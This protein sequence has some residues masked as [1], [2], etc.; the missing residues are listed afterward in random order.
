[1]AEIFRFILCRD[2]ASAWADAQTENLT[3][4]PGPHCRPRMPAG[5]LKTPMQRDR[6]SAAVIDNRSA[7]SGI[8]YPPKYAIEMTAELTTP[9]RPT[10]PRTISTEGEPDGTR[11]TPPPRH[12]SGAVMIDQRSTSRDGRSGPDDR[13]RAISSVLIRERRRRPG[14]AGDAAPMAPSRVADANTSATA[15]AASSSD[16][17]TRRQNYRAPGVLRI[18]VS[19]SPR[20][21][22]R[23]SPASH[24]EQRSSAWNDNEYIQPGTHGLHSRAA[25]YHC[26]YRWKGGYQRKG[27]AETCV[28]SS[29]NVAFRPI[30]RLFSMSFHPNSQPP[31]RSVVCRRR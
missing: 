2:D 13:V 7:I 28:T 8:R 26:S 24:S 3:S 25:P 6:H 5:V 29:V 10:I 1:M 31:L 22:G 4:W 30:F 14:G 12:G 16:S 20:H 15:S 21:P 27:P 17:S 11:S 23:S 9:H 18:E 19:G